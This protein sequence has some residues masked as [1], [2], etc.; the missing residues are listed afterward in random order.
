[1]LR[2]YGGARGAAAGLRAS[3]GRRVCGRAG[4]QRRGGAGAN[5]RCLSAP[6]PACAAHFP[7]RVCGALPLWLRCCWCCCC[8]SP[9]T[10]AAILSR[11][12]RVAVLARAMSSGSTRGRAGRGDLRSLARDCCRTLAEPLR[13]ESG[14]PPLPL[15]LVVAT[16]G[17]KGATRLRSR[18]FGREKDEEK[19]SNGVGTTVLKL[20]AASMGRALRWPEDWPSG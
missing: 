5:A 15:L 11:I 1:M 9:F 12:D 2:P 19:T 4:R 3:K 18:P 16:G 7:D 10:G 17:Q 20:L 13:F 8:V 6:S 14:I